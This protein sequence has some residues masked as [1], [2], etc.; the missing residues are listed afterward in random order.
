MSVFMTA[1]PSV[2]FFSVQR[3]RDADHKVFI[4]SVHELR[5]VHL[6]DNMDFCLLFETELGHNSCSKSGV[7][8]NCY[9]YSNNHN[10]TL[11]TSLA[12]IIISFETG[13]KI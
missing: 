12:T 2:L 13:L 3:D 1:D 9:S 6:D 10:E 11:L 5:G 8:K 7:F 4:L